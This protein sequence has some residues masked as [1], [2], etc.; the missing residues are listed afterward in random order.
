MMMTR[1]ANQVPHKSQHD[2]SDEKKSNK[3]STF[4]FG[5]LAATRHCNI[6]LLL[7]VIVVVF[8]G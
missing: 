7:V 1:R 2:E 4:W 5:T 3:D 8:G 6:A